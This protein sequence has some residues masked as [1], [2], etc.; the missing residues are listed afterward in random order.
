VASENSST[1]VFPLP[2]DLLKPFLGRGYR[3]GDAS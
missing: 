3:E 1:L 2:I